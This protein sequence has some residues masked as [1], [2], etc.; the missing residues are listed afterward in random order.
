MTEVPEHAGSGPPKSLSRREFGRVALG[1]IAAVP[2]AT[3]RGV[4]LPGGPRRSLPG[5]DEWIVVDALGGPGERLGGSGMGGPLTP[6]AL[7]DIRESGITAVN[8]TVGTV[9]NREGLFEEAVQDIATWQRRIHEHPDA[10]SQIRTGGDVREAKST[11]RLGIIFGFQDCAMME[12]QVE[13]VDVFHDLGVK[14]MQ[15]TYN[16]R[17]E[18]GDGSIEADNRGLTDFGREAVARMNELGVLVDLSHCGQQ[19]TDDGIRASSVPVSITHTGCRALADLP[20]NKNDVTLRMLSENGGVAGIYFMPFL[21]ESGQ[22]YSEHVI[23]H[24]E[25]ALDVCGEDHVGIGTDGRISPLH[26]TPEYIEQHHKDIEDRRARGISAPGE[27]T[28]VYT[29][30]PDLNMPRRFETLGDLLA[31]RG[32][33]SARIEKILGGNFMR[34]FEETW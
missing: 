32:H 23:Q 6:Q 8:L 27:T 19:T 4:T 30:I 33:G 21:L 17:N 26:L 2:V 12:G 25:H 18:L 24:I 20:R 1:A 5:Y 3:S 9:G 29:Y 22:P 15:L 31:A 13:R 11:E 34:L 14:I 28:D 16:R 10:L 7:S